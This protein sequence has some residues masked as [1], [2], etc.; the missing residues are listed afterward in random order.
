M[1]KLDQLEA[2]V[3]RINQTLGQPISDDL[4]KGPFFPVGHYF[5]QGRNG[6]WCLMQYTSNTGGSVDVTRAGS[7]REQYDSLYG[8]LKGIEAGAAA[9]AKR[10]GAGK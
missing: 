6:M 2:L 8:F 1:L 7:K 5:L 10:W 3:C 9:E 4:T